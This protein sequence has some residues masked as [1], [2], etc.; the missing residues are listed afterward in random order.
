MKNLKNI[1]EENI[2]NLTKECASEYVAFSWVRLLVGFFYSFTDVVGV[3]VEALTVDL[4]MSCKISGGNIK[5]NIATAKDRAELIA[6]GGVEVMNPSIL[7]VGKW[8]GEE[9]MWLWRKVIWMINLRGK[10]LVV[11]SV[12][13]SS[14]MGCNLELLLALDMGMEV[15]IMEEIEQEAA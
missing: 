2:A 10:H 12:D 7:Y 15:V 13:L 9:Y 11:Y 8:T 5:D 14:S 6:N 1:V 3:V 4:Y